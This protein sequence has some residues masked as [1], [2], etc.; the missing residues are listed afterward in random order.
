MEIIP[1]GQSRP[2]I[3]LHSFLLI[4]QGGM[5]V[6]WE[7]DWLEARSRLS[8][9][10][11]AV[12][13]A[14]S[15]RRFTF[16]ELNDRAWHLASALH[17]DGIDK[18]DRVAL[19]APNDIS[20][21]DL[22]FA[23]G[24]IGAI[25]VPL[26]WRLSAAELNDI[27]RDCE[28]S[29]LFYH[30]SLKPLADQTFIKNKLDVCS[31]EY[32][33]S[34]SGSLPQITP[35]N[36]AMQDPW[37]I[38]YTGGTTGKP[39]G[40]VLSH[41]SIDG[42]AINTIVSWNLTSDDVT[43]TYLPM[44]H[45][46]GLNALTLPILKIGGKVI[47]GGQFDADEAIRLLNEEKCTISLMVP[48]MYHMLIHHP[49]FEKTEFPSVKTFL[50]GGASCPH[51]IYEAFERRGIAFKEGYGLTEAGPNN[52]FIDPVKAKEK[53]GS[54][55]KPMMYNMVRVVDED[56]H[57]AAVNETGELWIQGY[58]L[59]DH[60][61]NN[62]E[63]TKEALANNWLHTGDLAKYDEDGDYYIL[64][65]KKDMIITGGENVYPLE[66]ENVISEHPA[67]SE[68]AVVGLPDDKWGERVAAFIVVKEGQSLTEEELREH[69]LKSLGKY[70][71]P[72][73]VF[74]VN[75]LPKTDVGK[76]DK[77]K[78]VEQYV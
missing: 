63:A 15:G 71:V 44:F 47:I 24:K 59:F 13:E 1:Y 22:L 61:W 64:G 35:P 67:V 28:P 73:T 5:N 16:R 36:V 19:L 41:R 78:I 54:V 18:G 7:T 21:L 23:C 34:V 43:L 32:D 17:H 45:T 66:V 60:Y 62:A 25:F 57:D 40:V 75:E 50:S 42:N 20:Y 49:D 33:D 55:G 38:I 12:V 56:G 27:L 11:E 65:R 8:P 6:N 29:I 2:A 69:C 58:H 30:Q 4:C 72:R 3:C 14:R 39:K 76:I 77:R 70:K 10:R 46:G 74:F 48:T 37:A 52:F 68:V 9:D 26:N 31:A 53:H 51:A